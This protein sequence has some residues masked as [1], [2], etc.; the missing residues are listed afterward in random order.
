MNNKNIVP[1]VIGYA[2]GL[3]GIY[4]VFRIASAGWAKGQGK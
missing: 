4:L 1:M 2:L 3:A